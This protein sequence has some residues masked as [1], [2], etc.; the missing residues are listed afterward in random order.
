MKSLLFHMRFF[1]LLSTALLLGNCQSRGLRSL[2][3]PDSPYEKYVQRLESAQLA[4]TAL[5]TRWRAVGQ[6]AL[7]DTVRRTLPLREAGYFAAEQPAATSLRFVARKGEVLEI[8]VR[9]T[10]DDWLLFADLFRL[11]ETPRRVA[12]AGDSLLRHEVLHD[13]DYLL[14]LQPEL[15]RSGRYEV[16]IRRISGLAFPVSG[17]DVRAIRSFFGVA[18]DGG[19]RRHEGVDIFAPRGTPVVAAAPGWIRSTADN[20]L[21]GKVVWLWEAARQRS[22]YYAHLDSHAVRAGQRVQTGDTLGFMG[23]TGNARTTPPHLHLGIYALGSG[24]I[25]PLPFLRTDPEPMPAGGKPDWLG[26]WLRVRGRTNLR[27][28]PTTRSL[29]VQQLPP[30][31]PVRAWAI[32]EQWYRVALPDGTAGFV[33]GPLLELATP[34]RTLGKAATLREGVAADALPIRT[35]TAEVPVRVLGEFEGVPLVELPGG[36]RGWWH[37]AP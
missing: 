11:D 26:Q 37:P 24:A 14:R 7:R 8:A 6:A 22:F 20:R 12:L 5:G 30:Q 3:R 10:P 19:R 27:Q 28:A 21:G 4:Q 17:H 31:T 29:V 16:S 36:D 34:L 9:T 18:R 32:A 25:D 1:L 33:F 15:L 23:N 13:S 2:I 35:L